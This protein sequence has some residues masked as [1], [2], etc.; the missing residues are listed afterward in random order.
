LIKAQPHKPYDALA[1][2]LTEP[3]GLIDLL[4]ELLGLLDADGLIDLLAE[5]LGLVD[6]DGLTE[7]LAELLGLVDAD[8]LTE[9]LVELLGLV[10]ADGLSD[11]DGLDCAPLRIGETIIQ[12]KS[13]APESYFSTT[14][15]TR[16]PPRAYL[17]FPLF[18][19][20]VSTVK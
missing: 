20:V 1:L 6:A 17:N 2:G 10:E 11:A 12:V 18:P 8:G 9:A 7:A 13:P 4:A 15:T 5:L 14:A 3:D 16:S 19:A